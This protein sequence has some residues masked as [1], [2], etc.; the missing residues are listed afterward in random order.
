MTENLAV[1]AI[2]GTIIENNRKSNPSEL[3]AH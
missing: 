2:R 3:S 1:D